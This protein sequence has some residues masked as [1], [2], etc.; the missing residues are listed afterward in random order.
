MHEDGAAGAA[1]ARPQIVPQHDH[2]IVQG[3]L[4]PQS[5]GTGWIGMSDGTVVV[6]V[7]WGVAP[8][9]GAADALRG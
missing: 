3:I 2:H 6:A 8:R 7:A 5:L 4:T 1:Q 9:V